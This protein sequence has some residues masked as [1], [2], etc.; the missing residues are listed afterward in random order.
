LAGLSG[1]GAIP[2]AVGGNLP[3]ANSYNLNLIRRE[4]ILRVPLY[5]RVLIFIAIFHFVAMLVYSLPVRLLR[6]DQNRDLIAYY[7]VIERIHNNEPIYINLS[8][9]GPHKPTHAFYLY[10]PILSS[11]LAMMPAM[12]FVT[13]AQV[14][15]L[16]L[17]VAFWIY[18]MCLAKIAAGHVTFTGALV[19]GLALTFF[20]GTHT[21]LSYGQVDPFLWALFG[22][23]LTVPA[24]KGAG[25]MAVTLVKPWGIWPLFWSLRDGWR[26]ITSA[27]IFAVGSIVLGVLVRGTDVFYAEWLTWFR[28]VLPLL[29]QGSWSAG[30]WSISFGVLRVIKGL[31]LWDYSGGLLPLWARLWLLFCGITVPILTGFFLRSKHIILQISVVGCSAVVFAPICWI[32]YLPVLLTV[33]SLLV[34]R[35]M[36]S[37][38]KTVLGGSFT[39]S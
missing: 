23:A 32:T 26:V 30:N 6:T 35:K 4:Y 1:V 24:I 33:L 39:T 10:P 16:L 7:L 28:D 36:S 27:L 38:N 11:M 5:R 2:N 29:G 12:S 17:Y 13:F 37:I 34:G 3:K 19:A 31:G 21:A 20:P 22:I 9:K 14:W 25:L 18:A 15:T 8:E